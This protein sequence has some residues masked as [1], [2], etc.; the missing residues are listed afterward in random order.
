MYKCHGCE[1]ELSLEITKA[2]PPIFIEDEGIF[3][4]VFGK[5]LSC[6]KCKAEFLIYEE[7][8]WAYD[9]DATEVSLTS[10]DPEMVKEGIIKAP[11]KK[12][13]KKENPI[14][15]H[16]KG[17]LTLLRGGKYVPQN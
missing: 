17:H 3:S 15:L 8:N 6:Q 16:K 4:V 12:E 9:E 11:G 7:Y 13:K 2:K 1:E 14:L 10:G 5:I